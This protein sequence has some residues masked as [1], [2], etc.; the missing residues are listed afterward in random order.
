MLRVL[1][2]WVDTFCYFLTIYW[3]IKFLRFKSPN[4]H[5][6]AVAMD[7]DMGDMVASEP[8]LALIAEKYHLVHITWITRKSLFPIFENHPL[9]HLQID[10]R[11]TLL[12]WFFSALNPFDTYINLH[13][14]GFRIDPVT[15]VVIQNLKADALDLTL[16]NY[17]YKHNLLDISC[18]LADVKPMN[19]Q[20]KLYLPAGQKSPLISGDYWV[21]HAKSN[22]GWRDWN[23]DLWRQLILKAMDTWNVKMVEVGHVHPLDFQHKNFLSLVGKTS[24]LEMMQVIEKAQFFIGLDSGP[25]HIANAFEIPALILCGQFRNF[26]TY[27]PYSGAYQQQKIAKIL[28]NSNGMAAEL[29]LEEVWKELTILHL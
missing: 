6:V 26:R 17:Y 5:F 20:P 7:G 28:F 10:Q 23:D 12:S 25:T 22:M 1:Q 3:R 4:I 14:S 24:L 2:Y 21:I 16:E 11:A 27:M 8:I 29:T 15:R 9:V 18:L 19:I 13:L